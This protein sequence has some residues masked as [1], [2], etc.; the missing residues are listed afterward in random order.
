MTENYRSI[1]TLEIIGF[2]TLVNYRGIFTTLAPGCNKASAF[3]TLKHFCY[4]PRESIKR[5]S[6]L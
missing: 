5:N 4:V 2:F 6:L 1:L 3:E